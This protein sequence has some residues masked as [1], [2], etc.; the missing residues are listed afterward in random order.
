VVQPR[1]SGAGSKSSG[2]RGPAMGGGA[3]GRWSV[4]RIATT[5]S[6]SVMSAMTR[7]RPPHGHAKASTSWTRLSSVAQS[8]RVSATGGGARA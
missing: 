7:R 4:M 1:Q 3:V 6:G 5:T 8:M 2:E